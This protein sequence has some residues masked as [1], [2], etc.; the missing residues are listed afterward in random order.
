MIDRLEKE[1]EVGSIR[2]RE[3]KSQINQIEDDMYRSKLEI[4]KRKKTLVDLEDMEKQAL[5]TGD[6]VEVE[7][8]KRIQNVLK[9]A[10]SVEANHRKLHGILQVFFLRWTN[11]SLNKNNKSLLLGNML[12]RASKKSHNHRLKKL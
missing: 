10:S 11:A 8:I 12:T 6:K 2:E 3:L 9:T 5:E 7:R 1:L 4:N